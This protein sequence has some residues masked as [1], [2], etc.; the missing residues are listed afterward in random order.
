VALPKS[1]YQ[2]F[3]RGQLLVGGAWRAFFAP[4]NAT[5]AITQTQTNKGPVILD[6]QVQGPF[7]D[8]SLPT[9]YTDLGWINGLK[10]NPASKIGMV[11]AGYRGA[12]RAL[13]RG[14]VGE[15]C[16]FKFREMSR[17]AMKIASGCEVFNLMSNSNAVASTLGPFSSSGIAAVPIGSSG[18]NSAYTNAGLALAAA[19]VLFLPASSGSFFTAGNYIVADQDYSNTQFGQVGDAGI[20]VFQNAVT[21]VDFTRK[22]SDY[23]ARVVSVIASTAAGNATGQ[24]I[25]VL[26]QKFV[27]GGN[28]T[29]TP[30]YGPTA[31]AKVQTIK[32]YATREGGT[33]ITEWSA[34][35]LM[36]TIDNSQIAL[37]YPHLAPNS[38]KGWDNWALEN[39]GTTDL[40]GYEMD[41][42]FEALAFD[43]PLDG[44][45]V[46]RYSAYY[47]A[48]NL[49]PAI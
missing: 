46:V 48:A 9:N 7:N 16:E 28:S 11:R 13:Y 19:P 20:P 5:L 31:G 30:N 1:L 6:L 22:T 41:A 15:S 25:L 36:Q 27:G 14:Q 34:L 44:E 8:Q 35:F 40:T 45:T 17:M 29:G 12:V 42:V 4:F 21:D 24:D 38:F 10:I 33:Y 49:N 37:Y 39:A 47:P 32:G 43:D 18:Y 23:V 2:P 3:R 26:D